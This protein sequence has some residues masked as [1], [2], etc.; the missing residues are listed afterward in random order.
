MSNTWRSPAKINLFLHINSKRKDG[1]HNLQSIFQLLDYCDQLNFNVRQDG[2][3]NRTS[4]NEDVPEEIDLIIKAA[5]A[6]QQATNTKLGADIS[7]VKNIPTGG[8][9]GGG[10]S[11]AATT[12]IALNQ[13]WNTQYS[14]QQLSEIGLSLGADV[15][16]FIAGHS[17]WAEGVGEI[18][19]P[20]TL[21]KHYFL[22]VSINKHI[23][24]KEI[25]SHKALT[26]TSQIGKMSDFSELINPHNDCL[27]A[28]VDLEG[29]V[30]KAL[31]HLES[32]KNY[33]YQPRMTGT[34]SCVFVEFK[35][36]KDALVA[37]DNLPKQWSGFV[38]QALNTSPALT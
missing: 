36:E 19:T 7:V 2:I 28:A 12:L 16:I 13:L 3:I 37:L 1:Y 29:E 14:N 32:A 38:A 6:L 9:L 17:A 8:G 11:N 15:P 4:G 26:I 34:G 21:P 31:V 10:S 24:T 33:L 25:F 22:V 18:L 30:L 5:K 27:E 20:M 35:H 23:S